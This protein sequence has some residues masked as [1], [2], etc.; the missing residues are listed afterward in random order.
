LSTR[1]RTNSRRSTPARR[2]QRFS[3]RASLHCSSWRVASGVGAVVTARGT[4]QP[5]RGCGAGHAQPHGERGVAGLAHLEHQ[6]VVVGTLSSLLHACRLPGPG[7][8][9]KGALPGAVENSYMECRVL[10][11][12]ALQNVLVDSGGT[13]HG[14]AREATRPRRCVRHDGACAPTAYRLFASSNRRSRIA[15]SAP[16]ESPSPFRRTMT[17]TSEAG[18]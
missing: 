9:G 6:P 16:S 4:P 17:P 10:W 1:S 11:Q 12:T 8:P 15:L 14:S 18:S 5:A 3:T 2:R 13:Q 7:R